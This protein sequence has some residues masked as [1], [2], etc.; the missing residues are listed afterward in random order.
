MQCWNDS[1]NSFSFSKNPFQLLSVKIQSPLLP[2]P[3]L[4][5]TSM[6]ILLLWL[7][8]LN[9]N[10][11]SLDSPRWSFSI[12]I[13]HLTVISM[14]I[15]RENDRR[16]CLCFKASNRQVSQAKTVSHLLN[17]H[18]ISLNN[19][20]RWSFPF[21]PILSTSLSI[22]PRQNPISV[23][24][25]INFVVRFAFATNLVSIQCNFIRLSTPI[26]FDSNLAD[27]RV[28]FSN[29]EETTINRNNPLPNHLID[30]F[31]KQRPFLALS[32]SSGYSV[33]KISLFSSSKHPFKLFLVKSR[34]LLFLTLISMSV[35]FFWPVLFLFFVVDCLVLLNSLHLT[36]DH[37]ADH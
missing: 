5:L 14:R 23:F 36:E 11:T 10:P 22:L 4:I 26:I 32:I 30:P 7:I 9:V 16:R 29:F 28:C 18:R 3:F 19:S 12:Q 20:W 33:I 25:G 24:L 13:W 6:F 31:L 17:I 15:W 27:N 37:P 2:P 1:F 35:L 34:F 8:L 21:L